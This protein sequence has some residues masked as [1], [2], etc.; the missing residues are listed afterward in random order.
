MDR[1]LRNREDAL[2]TLAVDRARSLLAGV[3]QAAR[4]RELTDASLQKEK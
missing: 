3:A 4:H 1:H 2:R